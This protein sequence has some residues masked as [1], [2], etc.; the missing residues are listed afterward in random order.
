MGF[1]N[2]TY[3][4]FVLNAYLT[5]K[6]IEWASYAETAAKVM[7]FFKWQE[8]Q[9]EYVKTEFCKSL[10]TLHFQPLQEDNA[11]IRQ[12]IELCCHLDE[13]AR[14][15]SSDIS[16]YLVFLRQFIL[17]KMKNTSDF[18]EGI[19]KYIS[20]YASLGKE[21]KPA[22][23][24]LEKLLLNFL[25]LDAQKV[26]SELRQFYTAVVK[27]NDVE[28]QLPD[29]DVFAADR[30]AVKAA[31][32]SVA[33]VADEKK[34]DV[35]AEVPPVVTT[36]EKNKSPVAETKRVPKP[37]ETPRTVQIG[38]A[39][40]FHLFKKTYE[41]MSR[42]GAEMAGVTKTVSVE[43]LSPT[44]KKEWVS[45]PTPHASALTGW[46]NLRSRKT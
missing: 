41:P 13:S 40:R 25:E 36:I 16:G 32:K 46:Y 14:K 27:L 30:P 4:P 12:W 11:S 33:V 44:K 22:L 45:P 42:W 39:V 26:E 23:S 1:P 24:Q 10:N 2:A 6:K 28:N 20:G 9:G 5:S 3:F 29:F 21:K 31:V 8:H 7:H 35:I 37:P 43:E 17:L 19:E 34:S 38:A 15:F 18:K